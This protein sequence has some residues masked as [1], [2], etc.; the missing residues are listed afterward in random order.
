[1]HH[2]KAE[3]DFPQ[4]EKCRAPTPRPASCPQS[5]SW[6][7]ISRA[8]SWEGVESII[9]RLGQIAGKRLILADGQN[10]IIAATGPELSGAIIEPLDEN[11]VSIKW[12]ETRRSEAPVPGTAKDHKESVIVPE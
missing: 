2:L 12:E 8:G 6:P 1:M 10:S 3:E 9:K 4:H 11:L 7:N 5:M